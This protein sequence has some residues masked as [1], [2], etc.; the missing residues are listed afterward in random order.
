MLSLSITQNNPTAVRSGI[1]YRNLASVAAELPIVL[2]ILFC[3]LT[4]PLVIL[5]SF[6]IRYN[7][8][9]AASRDAAFA[10][11]RCRT[12]AS[13]VSSTKQSAIHTAESVAQA[14]ASQFKEVSVSSVN[15][16]II[17]TKLKDGTVSKT[18]KA[19]SQ[20]ADTS[21]YAY[22]IEVVVS[23]STGPILKLSRGKQNIPGLTA[24]IN[25]SVCS[26]DFFENPQGL[27]Q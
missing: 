5:I 26:R 21:T 9:V 18:N 11:S 1:R 23:G 20:P 17:I 13:D 27:N 14:C 4:I 24:P 7:F 8:L 19:L 22:Q 3:G 15:T 16:N 2:W 12:F 25:V 6:S 10:A